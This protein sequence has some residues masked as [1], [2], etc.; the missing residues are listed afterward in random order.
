MRWL[1]GLL[2][3]IGLLSAGA[4]HGQGYV[5]EL[6]ES[7]V[8]DSLSEGVLDENAP[9]SVILDITRTKAGRD[10][11]ESFYQ[12]WSN[13]RFTAPVNV[14]GDSVLTDRTMTPVFN[15]NEYVITIEEL[16]TPNNGLTSLVSINVDN[17]VLWQQ[18]VQARRDILEEYAGYAVETVRQYFIEIQSMQAQLGDE[19]QK[20]TGIY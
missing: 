19:D 8:E 1:P 11:Y 9:N 16:V 3:L 12:Q 18:F 7:M 6:Q 20:G 17:Q 13:V 14:Q 4:G 15:L 5:D 10:F 2:L